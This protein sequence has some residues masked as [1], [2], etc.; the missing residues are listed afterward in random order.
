M[1][2]KPHLLNAIADLLFAAAAAAWLAAAAVWLVRMPALPIRQV[3]VVQ[4]LQHVR[5][6]EV[7]QALTGMLRGNF[8]SVNLE[9]V[10]GALEK[11]PWV[12]HAEVRRQWPAR[13][14]VTI[15]EHKPVARWEESRSLSKGELVNSFGEVFVATLPEKEALALPQLYGP[16]GTSQEV[17]KRYAEFTQALTP[18]ELKPVR[19]VLSPRLAWHVQLADGMVM[20][21]GREQPKAPVS[22][23]LSRFVEVYPTTV[24][25]RR[26][27][28]VAVDLRYPNGFA[29]RTR[30]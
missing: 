8:F 13:L 4:E 20:D 19:V 21:L 1:W 5:R 23:R 11:L 27:R 30:G 17:L 3:A 6:G 2:N 18:V 22:A 15:E 14:D 12:R 26:D 16:Q 10:R 9:A 24:A 7:E 29:M 28:P 25:T